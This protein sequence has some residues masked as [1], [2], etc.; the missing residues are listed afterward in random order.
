MFFV[1]YDFVVVMLFEV[2]LWR[3]MQNTA[4]LA[5][6]EKKKTERNFPLPLAY[7]EPQGKFTL[8]FLLLLKILK[9]WYFQ[10]RRH[11]MYTR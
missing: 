5:R 10:H 7:L 9:L 1:L 11:I 2:I 4:S 3:M 6:E 8:M